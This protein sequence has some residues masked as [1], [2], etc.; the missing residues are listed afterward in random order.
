MAEE[1]NVAL[2]GKIKNACET[3]IRNHEGNKTLG[4]PKPRWED[5]NVKMNR[6]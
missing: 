4:R 3:V 5:H 2:I 6:N 1:T